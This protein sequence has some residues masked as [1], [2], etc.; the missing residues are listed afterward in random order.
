MT[1]TVAVLHGGWSAE[2]EVSLV[3]GKAVAAAL[4]D[5]GHR[6]DLIDVTRD[7][8]A[9]LRALR[10]APE[11]VFNALHGKGGEDGTIQ[12]VLDMLGLPYT[13]SGL[14]P[15][16]IAMSKPATKQVVAAVGIRTARGV[17]ATPQQVVERHLFEPPYVVKPAEEGSSVGVRIVRANDNAPAIDLGAWHFGDALVEEYIPGRELT[18]GV[19]GDRALTV[20]EIAHSH[21]FFDYEAKY[22]EGHAVH[23][24]PA[25]VPDLVFTEAMRQALLAHRT[26]GCRGISRSDFRWDDT[27]PG[28]EGLV[29]LEL[30]TQPGFT[31][32]SLVPEQA[33][34]VG[35]G[36]ADLCEWLLGEAACDR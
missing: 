35:I 21:A 12:G 7:L 14:R 13:H 19:M 22:T 11:V 32:I 29:F 10:P 34:H 36:F 27:R 3:S 6:V 30:N 2:R 9:L 24:L 5:R 8:E 23:T 1:K 26:L 25:R 4:R 18:V 28:A 17:V 16:A 20:T 31:P 15:S 33:K